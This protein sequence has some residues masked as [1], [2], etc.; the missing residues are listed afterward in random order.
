MEQWTIYFLL[1]S[2]CLTDFNMYSM[3]RIIND[4]TVR[5]DCLDYYVFDDVINYNDLSAYAHQN[6]PYCISTLDWSEDEDN[7]EINGQLFLFADLVR[8][9]IAIKDLMAWSVSID[10]VERFEMYLAVNNTEQWSS[11][12]FYNCSEPFFGTYCQYSFTSSFDSFY[13]YV[14]F[15]FSMHSEYNSPMKS[16]TDNT[17][18]QHLTCNRSAQS[19]C[20]D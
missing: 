5:Y 2:S 16:L 17:C 20:L 4:E 10:I 15:S 14:E 3:D 12:V 1:I 6:I 9:N 18:Y 13:D 8:A 11:D 7:M 19:F